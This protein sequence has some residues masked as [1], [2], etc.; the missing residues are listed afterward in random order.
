LFA[1]QVFEHADSNKDGKVDVADLQALLS[2]A[3]QDASEVRAKETL[4]A[5]VQE[6]ARALGS[7]SNKPAVTLV[8]DLENPVQHVSLDEFS[9]W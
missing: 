6:A 7:G 9:V 8:N 3:G 2:N 1:S 4:Q 5:I